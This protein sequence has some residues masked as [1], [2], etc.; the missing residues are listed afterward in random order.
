MSVA[1][2]GYGLISRDPDMKMFLDETVTGTIRNLVDDSV[3]EL[4]RYKTLLPDYVVKVSNNGDYTPDSQVQSLEYQRRQMIAYMRF[5]A[6][7][8]VNGKEVTRTPY[9]PVN[10]QDF[11]IDLGK[12]VEIRVVNRPDDICVDL[13][14]LSPGMC[15]RKD[16]FVATIPISHPGQSEGNTS[17]SSGSGT[18]STR[19]RITMTHSYAPITKWNEFS[20]LECRHRINGVYAG[21]EAPPKL[22]VDGALLCTTEYDVASH[23]SH[24]HHSHHRA[25]GTPHHDLALMPPP[26][27]TDAAGIWANSLTD[28]ARERDFQ[29]LL[30]NL[31]EIDFNDPRHEGMVLAK[32]KG[33]RIQQSDVFQLSGLDFSTVFTEDGD[34]F[35]NYVKYQLGLRFK[36]LQLRERKPY[37]FSAPI[38]LSEKDIKASE[39]YKQILLKHREETSDPDDGYLDGNYLPTDPHNKYRVSNFLQRVRGAAA[40][41]DKTARKKTLVT[42]SVVAET[43]YFETT[44][45]EM[46]LA[47]FARKRDL[48]P[49]AKKRIPQAMHV[50]RCELLVQVVGAKNVPL[51]AEAE[52]AEILQMTKSQMKKLVKN[53]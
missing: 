9:L 47:L 45:E 1:S 5:K 12:Y 35:R 14:T 25:E 17:A 18:T 4:T 8:K 3:K 29:K 30:P 2:G 24:R 53:R 43:D 38:P 15:I 10:P 52:M 31:R 33:P 51:R 48:K 21:S 39:L 50:D 44:K 20:S 13:Y 26:M 34:S 16:S 28:F 6:V 22:E 37:L 49:K 36:L 23:D 42:S 7:V 27:L 46:D 32:L 11:S 41:L 40:A 19:G